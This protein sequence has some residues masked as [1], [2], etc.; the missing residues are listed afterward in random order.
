[1][2][3]DLCIQLAVVYQGIYNYLVGELEF[4]VRGG[5]NLVSSSV[6]TFAHGRFLSI[7]KSI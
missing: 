1:M 3:L 7:A 2:H 5:D 4:C 6:A